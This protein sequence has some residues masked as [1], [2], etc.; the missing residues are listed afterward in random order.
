M[1][2]VTS[3]GHGVIQALTIVEKFSRKIAADPGTDNDRIRKIILNSYHTWRFQQ[4]VE[5]ICF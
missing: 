5:F 4:T 1:V 3:R 2:R